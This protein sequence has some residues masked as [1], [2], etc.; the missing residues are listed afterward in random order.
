MSKDVRRQTS[1]AKA[2]NKGKIESQTKENYQLKRKSDQIK[3]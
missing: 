2:Q 3:I 1:K